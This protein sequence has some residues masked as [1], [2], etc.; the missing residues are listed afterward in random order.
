[1]RT[2]GFTCCR[3]VALVAWLAT[4]SQGE[5]SAHAAEL[6]LGAATADITP[7]QPVPLSGQMRTR[8]SQRV[9][10]PLLASVL[11]IESREGDR[12]LD[13]A[14]M[15]ACD[16]VAIREGLIEEV[17]SKLKERL[18]GFDPRKLFLSA[19]HT[20]TAPEMVEGRYDLPASGI[21]RP[22]DYK[23]FFTDRVVA[24]I[25]QAWNGRRPG[26]VGWGLGHAVVAQN[27]LAVAQDGTSKMYGSTTTPTFARFESYEDH[28]VEVLC[29][30]D[31][32][33][34]LVATAINVA[35]PAQEVEGK[36]TVDADFWHQV[37][38]ALRQRHGDQLVVLG[39]TGAG[40]DQSPHLMTRKGAEERMRTLRGLDRLQEVSRRIVTAWEDA[41]AGAVQEKH[42]DAPLV[43]RVQTLQLP[44]RQ[45]TQAESLAA[46]SKVAELADDPAALRVRQWHQKVVDRFERQKPD[47]LFST[48]VH[49]LRLGDVAIATNQFEL[50][51]DYGLQMKAR[52]PA[53]QTFV[54]QLTGPGSY[55][56]TERGVAGGAYGAVIQSNTVGPEGGRVLVERTLE[57]LNELWGNK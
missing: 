55:L 34:K 43:H 52:S 26:S 5:P 8:I 6:H 19:T 16:L 32:T 47:D 56:P 33:G 17:R 48:E 57:T 13:Q 37:R 44:V 1:M 45:V 49:L 27:R 51:T 35:C 2:W 38:E 20:H 15:V 9:D 50:Y 24:A 14:I 28:G 21:M 23:H 42:A 12:S 11:V 10:S 54:I 31:S 46:R 29:C 25:E 22:D 40:G 53:L 41:Y 3:I 30:W 18:P 39:W 36:S 7:D 4:L